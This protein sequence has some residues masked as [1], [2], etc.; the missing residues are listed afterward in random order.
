M[1]ELVGIKKRFPSGDGE[2]RCLFSDLSLR[3][4]RGEFVSVVGANGSGK[5][6]LLGIVG[7]S[8]PVDGGR[9]LLGGADITLQPEHLRARRIG[10]VMQDPSLG[11]VPNLSIAENIALAENK[12]KPYPLLPLRAKRRHAAYRALL[13]PFGL[14][15]EDRLSLPVGRLSGGQRQCLALLL[16]TLTPIDL[17]LLD[18]HTAALDPSTARTVLA[19]TERIAREK[20]IAALMVTHDLP[21]ALAFGDRLLLLSAGRIALD[22]RG[23]EK[24]RT[25]HAELLSLLS[26]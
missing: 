24:R 2:E 15:L 1:L 8:V 3:V 6:T 19:F 20:G 7:G 9:I 4:G 12:G 10:R 5:S 18:E 26:V 14:G 23:E 17:L 22:R 16:A 25:S 11:T 13:A 21:A